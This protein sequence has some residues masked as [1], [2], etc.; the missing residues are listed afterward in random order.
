MLPVVHD[1]PER[2]QDPTRPDPVAA[3]RPQWSLPQQILRLIRQR[4][5]VPDDNLYVVVLVQCCGTLVT[6][7]QVALETV[8]DVHSTL[9]C[10]PLGIIK[11]GDYSSVPLGFS[12]LQKVHQLLDELWSTL[13]TIYQS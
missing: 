4:H 12:W 1:G 3:F 5:I 8:Y 7:S 11:R 2:D 6:L 13:L 9:V 10:G